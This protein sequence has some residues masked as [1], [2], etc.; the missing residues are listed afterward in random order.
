MPPWLND[1]FHERRICSRST[2]LSRIQHKHDP[3]QTRLKRHPTRT[4][5][6]LGGGGKVHVGA[7][8]PVA[9]RLEQHDGVPVVSLRGSMGGSTCKGSHGTTA[10]A[11]SRSNPAWSVP[12]CSSRLCLAPDKQNARCFWYKRCTTRP[13]TILEYQCAAVA[14]HVAVWAVALRQCQPLGVPVKGDACTI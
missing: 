9:L 8:A 13:R 1:C 14:W 10:F 6:G 2:L 4:G 3:L 5:E 12:S 11:S 7:G